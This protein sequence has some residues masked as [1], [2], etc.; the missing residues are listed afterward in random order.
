MTIKALIAAGALAGVTLAAPAQLF[1]EQVGEP[2]EARESTNDLIVLDGAEISAVGEIARGDMNMISEGYLV[3]HDP[4]GF[5]ILSWFFRDPISASNALL[6]HRQD[7]LDR[8]HMILK[9]S[10]IL[11][12]PP[13]TLA[14][15]LFKFDPFTGGFVYQ[16]RYPTTSF[17][18]NL[19]MEVDGQSTLVAAGLLAPASATSNATLLRYANASGLPIFHNEYPVFGAP[20]FNG[21]FFDVAVDQQTGDIFAVGSIEVD[22]PDNFRALRG[23]LI[24]RF[25]PMGA[26]IWF[27]VYEPLASDSDAIFHTGTSITLNPAGDVAVTA[28]S[29]NASGGTSALHLIVSR[30]V[31]APIGATSVR[32]FN[33]LPVVPA[34]SSLETLADGTLLASGTTSSV[35]GADTPSMWDFDPFTGALNWFYTPESFGVEGTSAIAQPGE[36]VLL[37]GEWLAPTGPIGGFNDMLLARTTPAGVGYCDLPSDVFETQP[38]INVLPLQVDPANIPNP[39]KIQLEAQR[40]S[41]VNNV[42]C[43]CPA[44]FNNNGVADFPD[45]G[46]FLAAWSGGDLAADFNNNGVT[47]FPD[48]GL[49]LA[50]WTAGCP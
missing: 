36:G 14:L 8:R 4:D 21:R 43:D 23:V 30:A 6:A 7:P 24:A 9:E 15:E 32:S 11:T 31:G 50:A 2:D 18:Q 49:F 41:P 42:V 35:A 38:E 48:V 20:A 28:R 5:P 46:L 34:F 39:E 3:V 33:G 26:P 17:G 25:D 44:D 1:V 40:G 10:A 29:E 13:L 22:D 37:G 45:V 12:P 19:G 27:N 47:D 16:W